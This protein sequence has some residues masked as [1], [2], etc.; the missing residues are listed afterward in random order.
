MVKVGIVG[1]GGIAGNHARALQNIDD[2]S[3]SA[4]AD[5]RR[6]RAQTFSQVYREGK[7]GVYGSLEEMLDQE[8]LDVVHVCT[9]HYLHVP[10]TVLALKKGCDVFMEKPPAISRE[11]FQALT[12]AELQ[13]GKEIGVCFQNRYNETTKKADELLIQGKIG[14]V[15]AARAFVTWNRTADYYKK[16]GWR[17]SWETE[18]GGALIN[19]SIHTLDLLVHFLGKH[20]QV[21]ASMANHHLKGVIEVE[22]TVEAYISFEKAVGCFYATTAYGADRPVLIELEGEKGRM[23]L[24]DTKL[25]VSMADGEEE[26]YSLKRREIFGKSYWG[27]GHQACISDFYRCRRQGLPY[28]NS[29]E[30]T[31]ATFELMMDIYESAKKIK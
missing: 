21:E 19:Q 12:G 16:S 13:W 14:T 6:E 31:A 1:C 2:V 17:G 10:M 11:Q 30:S 20:R 15:R 22:D 23:R 7:A 28:Q 25:Y 3:L 27:D 24:E 5:I 26:E 9:P 8:N 18:G 29:L 4:F